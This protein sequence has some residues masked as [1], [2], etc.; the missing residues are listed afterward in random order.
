[1]NWN[2]IRRWNS[3]QAG[4]K[5]RLV[6]SMTDEDIIASKSKRWSAR[7]AKA[8][9][10]NIEPEGDAK[11]ITLQVEGQSIL[12]ACMSPV[13]PYQTSLSPLYQPLRIGSRDM[14]DGAFDVLEKRVL[15]AI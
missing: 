4:K 5:A 3:M 1:M 7:D 8:W 12:L 10:L 6:S 15:E 9:T 13:P 14:T 11:R 2:K